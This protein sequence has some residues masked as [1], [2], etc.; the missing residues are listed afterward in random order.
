MLLMTAFHLPTVL[1]VLQST[2]LMR[3]GIFPSRE[4]VSSKMIRHVGPTSAEKVIAVL[5]VSGT[6]HPSGMQYYRLQTMTRIGLLLGTMPTAYCICRRGSLRGNRYTQ[7]STIGTRGGTVGPILVPGMLLT[8]KR[9]S[10]GT[11]SWLNRIC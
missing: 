3:P 6:H 7:S 2:S 4:M 5:Q 10:R 1:L 8:Y 9:L 11:P